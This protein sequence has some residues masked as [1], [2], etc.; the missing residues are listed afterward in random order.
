ML[1][2]RPEYKYRDVVSAAVKLLAFPIFE[3]KYNLLNI[4]DAD[5]LLQ[6]QFPFCHNLLADLIDNNLL[7]KTKYSFDEENIDGV[8]FSYQRISD[9][10]IAREIV[11]KF[12]ELGIVYRKHKYRQN[13]ALHFC[14]QALGIQRNS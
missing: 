10:I 9:F 6:Q 8:V 2:R 12:Q 11:N 5:S 4:N 7:L 3:A 13:F 14:R 1:K